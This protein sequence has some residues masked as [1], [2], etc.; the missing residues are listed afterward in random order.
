MT[1][2]PDE[3]NNTQNVNLSMASEFDSVVDQL[4]GMLDSLQERVVSLTNNLQVAADVSTQVATIL[5]PKKL[6][7]SL[8]E[9]VKERFDLYHVHVYMLNEENNQL[10]LAAGAG[11]AGRAMLESGHAIALDSEQSLVARAAREGEA[12]IVTDVTEAE[13]W[14]PNP[15]L[16]DTHSE[17]AVPMKIGQRVIGV[18]DVQSEERGRFTDMDRQVQ[19]S[20]AEQLAIAIN[21][22]EAFAR[23][24]EVRAE[25]LLS[26]Q[27]IQ[28]SNSGVSI[29]DMTKPDA[30]LMFINPAFEQIT[31][32]TAEEV[33][34]KN[35]RFLQSDDRDQPALD[36]IRLALEEGR[37]TTVELRNYRKDGTMFWNELSLSPLYDDAGNVTHYVGVQT[38]ITERRLSEQR[39]ILAYEIGQEL[40]AAEDVKTLLQ[41]AVDRLA[42]AFEYYHAHIYVY[43]PK[44][45]RLVVRA[46][47]GEAGDVMM[48]HG[49]AI[50]LD[51][52]QSLV[53]TAAR[54]LDSVVVLDVREDPSHLPNPLIPDTMSEAAIPLYLGR[55]LLGVLDVQSSSVGAFDDNEVRLL[56]VIANQ[57]STA[58]S[59]LKQLE[60]AQLRLRDVQVANDVASIITVTETLPDMLSQVMQRVVKALGADNAAFVGLTSNREH[61]EG[62][63]GANMDQ[64]IIDG[65]D[66][67]YEDFPHAAEA[68]ET[69]QVVAVDNAYEY[70]NF[71]MEY[72]ES[73]GIKSVAAV[74]VIV[75]AIPYGV[76]FFNFNE[77][78][79]TFS[80]EEIDLLEGIARQLGTAIDR[81]Q[82]EAERARIY[83]M[84]RDMIGSAGFDGYFKD[85]NPAWERVTGYTPEELMAKPFIE[86]VHPDDVE[87]TNAEAAK[88]AEGAESLNFTNRYQ[89]KD[90]GIVWLQWNAVPDYETE[91]I[92]F[93]T[94]DITEEREREAERNRIYEMS[95]DMIGSAGFDGYF[96]DLNP[97]WERITGFT[98]EELMSKPFIEFVHPDDVESTNAEAAKLAEGVEVIN[99]TNRYQTKDGGWVWLSWNSVPDYE[100][101]MIYFATRDI[102]EQREREAERN[103][104]YEMSLDMIGSAG[105]DGYFKDLNPAWERITGF[106]NEELKA[107]PFIEFVHP[108][109][110]ASTNAE[111]AK[112]AEG[113]EAIDFINRYQTK[114]GGWVWLSWNS[115]PD[116]DEQMIYFVTRDITDAHE[117]E[118]LIQQR[119]RDLETV[120][121]IATEAANNLNLE[122]MLVQVCN[123]TKERFGHYHAH[124]YLLD[125]A[126]ETLELAAGAGNAGR[127]MVSHG[128]S[129]PFDRADSLVAT[130]ARK[131]EGVYSNDVTQ[132]ES[133][134]PNPLLPDTASEL[135][136]PLEVNRQVIGVLDVQSEEEGRFTDADILTH[137]ILAQQIGVA[138]SNARNFLSEQQSRQVTEVI[139]E[140]NEALSAA[141][142]EDDILAALE[143][144]QTFITFDQLTLSYTSENEREIETVATHVGGQAIDVSTLPV[145]TATVEQFP[146][147]RRLKDNGNNVITVEDADDA[148]ML[149]PGE[150]QAMTQLNLQSAV[151]MTP[152]QGGR[153]LAAVTLGSSQ[154]QHYDE[155]ALQVLDRVRPTITASVIS[156]L[157]FLAEQEASEESRRRA[158]E[159][160]TV[161]QVSTAAST[162]LDVEDLLLSV[163]DL[164]KS[165][166][167]LYHAHIYL[168]D[169]EGER[170]ALAAGAGEAGQVMKRHG[171]AIP[172]ASPTS[173]VAR[174]ARE[175]TSI[176]INNVT[177]SD[178]FMPNPLLPETRSELAIPMLVGEDLVGVLDVQSEKPNRFSD[179]EV[180]VMR[181]LASQ[182]AV[183]VENAR[184][185]QQAEE[186]AERERTAADSLREVDRLKSEFLASM[187][188]ELRTPLNS[189]IG[190]SEVMLDGG[191]GDLNDEAMEDI[192]IIYTSGKHLLN[193]INDILD[194]A[195]IE[196]NQMQIHRTDTDL[197][198]L[199]R[200]I[201][202]ANEVLVGDRPIDLEFETEVDELIVPVD[203]LRIRQV[204]LNLFSNAV[205]FT[206][207]G[208]VGIALS[209]LDDETVQVAVRDT[210][211]GISKEGQAIVFDQF[212]Q[213]DGSSTRK[214]GGTGLGLP[215]TRH[216]V[217]M[218]GGEIYVDSEEGEG[219]TFWFTLPLI[220]PEGSDAEAQAAPQPA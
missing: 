86:F 187:S 130:A 15:L 17:M 204:V 87:R 177:E 62:I 70:E 36:E 120:S 96:K 197:V 99:F 220:Q 102:T 176:R 76:A 178:T 47:L 128:H 107:K 4:R 9:T 101:Q 132:S 98:N 206:E 49:H 69:Y 219:S 151:F 7:P 2:Q 88:M 93:V 8:V 124:I 118:E 157:N 33:V 168:Y 121:N 46:G 169:E 194:L 10:E 158:R 54:D 38:D 64:A 106:S 112:L 74:P 108:D 63:A 14:L 100:A 195:K 94:R 61:W 152:N 91:T 143:P 73:I 71:P 68:V 116:Y 84:S 140:V 27:A 136:I 146:L 170:L 103:R 155:R 167:D 123:L 59:N 92:Y 131:V 44:T 21:N 147:I 182:V 161:A 6:L 189:I 154:P 181:T 217:N 211:I 137:E 144:L 31:G 53:A 1:Q 127:V 81:L 159:M 138:I 55:D 179:D 60:Q 148:E 149:T 142:D 139:A 30:P 164:T 83:D 165:S 43:E 32:Y 119:A 212:R 192:E 162:I 11:D 114:D 171:H 26:N 39:E 208:S 184:A 41:T 134:L 19:T 145:T 163:S 58:L 50:D 209:M 34:G 20:L 198:K 37:A 24:Q 5:E 75:S 42:T 150:A 95:R 191:D 18:L 110:V 175:K 186:L 25:L 66:D 203:E 135:A 153:W 51:T 48:R 141:L 16:P 113:V 216:L 210:G 40:N 125:D 45:N 193:I 202:K 35:C 111:A 65:I 196:A 199:L 188:H 160:E 78:F 200:G 12:L 82:A 105:F 90:G 109:D 156:R 214:A 85:L 29:A 104:I 3:R 22:A 183:A 80:D 174:S 97:A 23:V 52:P 173:I 205:K 215:I 213:V 185:F 190:Y 166:F 133:F 77:N 126:G 218:H 79:H 115:V 172:Y 122:D 201:I 28:A 180:A 207:E 72:V 89:T 13:T 67:D 57:L 129:I 56:R 117:R